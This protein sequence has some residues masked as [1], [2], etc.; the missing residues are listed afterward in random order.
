MNS[1]WSVSNAYTSWD[2][3]EIKFRI[4]ALVVCDIFSFIVILA[5]I[6]RG[7]K[8]ALLGKLYF[9]QFVVIA[10]CYGVLAQYTRKLASAC[11]D[12]GHQFDHVLRIAQI[13]NHSDLV[14][15]KFHQIV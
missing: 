2:G 12:H 6:I 8:Q 4:V 3:I 5:V 15:E 13:V 10:A 14:E 7:V 1:F 11:F 9:E